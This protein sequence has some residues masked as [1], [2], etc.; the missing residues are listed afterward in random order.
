MQL[1]NQQDVHASA[2]DGLSDDASMGACRLN[3]EQSLRGSVHYYNDPWHNV[4]NFPP[5]VRGS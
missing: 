3:D 2:V 4:A 5:R 1:F